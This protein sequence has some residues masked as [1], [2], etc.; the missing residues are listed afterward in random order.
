MH[1]LNRMGGA[2]ETGTE[3][4]PSYRISLKSKEYNITYSYMF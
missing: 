2:G 4:T 3:R 1:P